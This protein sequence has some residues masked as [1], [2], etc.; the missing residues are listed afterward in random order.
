MNSVS[1]TPEKPSACRANPFSTNLSHP[2]EAV[3][4]PSDDTGGHTDSLGTRG[5]R[6]AEYKCMYLML[7]GESQCLYQET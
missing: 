7:W 2:V 1:F 3:H 4:T 6:G 5:A